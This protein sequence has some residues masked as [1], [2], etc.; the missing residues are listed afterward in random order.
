[1]LAKRSCGVGLGKEVVAGGES[2]IG[3]CGGGSSGGMGC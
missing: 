2:G 3:L 1:M